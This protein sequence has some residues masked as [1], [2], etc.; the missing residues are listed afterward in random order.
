MNVMNNTITSRVADFLEK[1]PPFNEMHTRDLLELSSSIRIL[2]KEKGKV[3]FR[4]G[5][6]GHEEFYVVHKGAVDLRK[7]DT[8]A[9]IDICDEG[10]I[11][12]LRPLMANESYQLDAKTFEESIL[13]AIPIEPF[14]AYVKT[15]EE[16]GNFL[17]ESFAANTRNPYSPIPNG[18]LLSANEAQPSETVG[19][20]IDFQPIRYTT[21]IIG[22][23]PNTDSNT[24]AQLMVKKDIGSVLVQKKGLPIGIITTTDLLSAFSK[25]DADAALKAKDVMTTPII[26]YPKDLS[27]SQAQM[28]LMKNN[29]SH[30]CLTEDGTVHTPAVGVLST[31]DIMIALGNS[32]VAIMKAIT[33]AKKVKEL[34]TARKNI[35]VLL[36]DYLDSNIPVSISSKIIAELN[37]ACMK[38]LIKLV[39]AKK[40][41]NPPVAFA[42]LSLGSQGRGEQLL[43]TDQDNAILFEDVPEE[44]LPKTT[45]FFL[46][47]ANQITKGLNKIGYAYCPAE[48]MAS[49]PSWCLSLNE[50]KAKTSQWI[51][52]PGSNEVLQSSI[53]FDYNLT[54]GD[55]KL[56][57][58]L[59]KHIFNTIRKYPVFYFHLAAGA[60]Q[61]P[62]PTGFFRRFLLEQDGKHKDLFDLKQRALMPLTDAARVLLLSHE[63]KKINNTSERFEKL[64]ELE[65]S[66][67]DLYLSCS[68]ATKA[69]MKFRAKQGIR[70]MDTGRYI[71]IDGLSKEEKVKLKRTFKIIKEI[72]DIVAVRFKV[73]NVLR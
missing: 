53:F 12:G 4:K 2:Y 26:T 27:I 48:M 13:Y 17:I 41:N 56:V 58:T 69:L 36:K 61:Y 49:N 24:V 66:N 19:N 23:G 40:K 62:S 50:W 54:Y 5:E 30:L 9:I 15:Y 18:R 21:K 46:E 57:E 73:S 38:Q 34:R 29:I 71:Q 16:L 22:V 35:R 63:I 37:D 59:T 65:P 72:Q 10:D 39:L 7:P 1:Y 52:N 14:K 42:W 60:L 45:E 44:D 28:A 47:L 8:D 68:Y 32:P 64:A 31:Q 55:S 3:I 20:T 43:Q 51:I 25:K 70:N 33:R 6:K 67:R 11:F